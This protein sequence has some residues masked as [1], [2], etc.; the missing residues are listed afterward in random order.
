MK[1]NKNS[2]LFYRYYDDLYFSK[3]YKKEADSVVSLVRNYYPGKI[4][5][6]LEVG[7]GTG[8]HTRE[9]ARLNFSITAI[10]TDEKMFYAALKK[11]PAEKFPRVKLMN[12][13]VENLKEKNF[14]FA[15]AGFNVV[16]YLPDFSALLSFFGA[17]SQRLK[18]KGLLIF[19][20]WNGV[21]AIIDPPGSKT[22]HC[23]SGKNFVSCIIQS[24]T[25][26]MAQKTNLVYSLNV[27]NEKG[28]EISSGV[29]SFEQTLWT[30][31][32][33]GHCIHHAGLK[34]LLCSRHFQ[35]GI[36]ADE[37]E[38]KIMFVCQ[39]N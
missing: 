12:L 8:N 22:I 21:A 3:D 39:K 37:N 6:M 23:K 14:D 25:S 2:D 33:L 15:V 20:C 38:W 31:M 10:D 36:E 18:P 16:N 35:P 28:K 1:N 30:P 9:F 4:K 26:L 29:F 34:I 19:D 32:E 24:E 11:I 5:K 27:K 17:V 13:P 7:S